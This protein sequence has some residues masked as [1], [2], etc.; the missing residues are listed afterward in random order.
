MLQNDKYPALIPKIQ[1]ILMDK[2]T[3]APHS[4]VFSP[5]HEIGTFLCR[6]CGWALFRGQHHFQSSCG[7]PSFDAALDDRVQQRPDADLLRSEILCAR[8]EGHLGHIFLGEGHTDKNT[9]YCVIGSQ[10]KSACFVHDGQQKEIF[11]DLFN[12]LQNKGYA[13]VTQVLP[14]S[15]FWPAEPGHQNIL[16]NMG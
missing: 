11:V 15:A 2:A 16:K 13:A 3:E 12:Q 5:E 8:C 1:H 9:R 6:G 7:W 4:V 14:M 10:Y